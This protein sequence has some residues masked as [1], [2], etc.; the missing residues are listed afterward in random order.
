MAF[1][2]APWKKGQEGA[3]EPLAVRTLHYCSRP[4]RLLGHLKNAGEMGA[5]SSSEGAGAVW[6]LAADDLRQKMIHSGRDN[7]SV[8]REP[9]TERQS[10]GLAG[11][12]RRYFSGWA[13]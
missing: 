4:L 5:C 3:R 2:A 12:K 11:S 1:I 9:K 13:A 8:L 7:R 6:I 10:G